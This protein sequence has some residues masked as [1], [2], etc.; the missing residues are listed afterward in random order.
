MNPITSS[1]APAPTPVP[2]HDIVGPVWF[3]PWPLWMV[4]CAALGTILLVGLLAW[5]LKAWLAHKRPLTNQERAL[6]AL[7]ALRRNMSGVEPYAFGVAVS[8]GVRTYIHAQHGLPSTTKT[9]IEFLDSIRNNH[10]FTDNEKAGLAVFLEGTD[11]LKF[12]RAEAGESEMIGLLETAGRLVRG[13][14]QPGKKE[15]K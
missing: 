1:P 7:E 14:V 4:V 8:D 10:V 15:S 2:I 6:A 9:S 5:G 11:F 12:A 13:E 3:L